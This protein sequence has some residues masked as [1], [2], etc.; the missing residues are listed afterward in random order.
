MV[1]ISIAGGQLL[2]ALDNED[3]KD[4]V[5]GAIREV[6]TKSELLP[7]P[8]YPHPQ[9]FD[10]QSLKTQCVKGGGGGGGGYSFN[11]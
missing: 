6:L 5:Q 7:V 8:D 10:Q 9:G 11:F 2:A 1:I 4:D 3:C